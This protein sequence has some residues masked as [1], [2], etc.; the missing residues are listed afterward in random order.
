M[1]VSALAYDEYIGRLG[2][3]RIY[4]GVLKQGETFVRCNQEG[5]QKKETISNLFVY[6]G[7]SR[8]S[9]KE[10]HS[11]DIV[12]IAGMP[13][14]SIGDTICAVDS[15]EPM[16][17]I[18]IEEPTLSM[19]FHVNTSPFAGQSGKYVTSRNIKERLEKN[20]KSMLD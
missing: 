14:I 2:I 9:V 18:A 15:I 11:G 16:E 3:G 10:A 6:K 5:L 4:D 12:V 7:L 20:S 1:Q 19:N 8:T 17:H 13:D